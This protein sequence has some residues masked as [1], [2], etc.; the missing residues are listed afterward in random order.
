M[1]LSSFNTHRNVSD[2]FQ[3]YFCYVYISLLLWF[4]ALLR[5]LCSC[6][7]FYCT[8]RTVLLAFKTPNAS[9]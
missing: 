5:K 8:F 7:Y 9:S 3:Y 4:S 1:E 6:Y 2:F